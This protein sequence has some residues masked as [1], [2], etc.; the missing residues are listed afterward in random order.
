[1]SDQPLK[2]AQGHRDYIT[3]SEGLSGYFAVRVWWNVAFGCWEPYDTG[4]GR[5]PTRELAEEEGRDWAE[6]EGLEFIGEPA[7]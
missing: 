2:L 6:A 4:I 1:M 5:Y 3:T 7:T